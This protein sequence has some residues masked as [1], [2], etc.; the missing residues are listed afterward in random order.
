MTAEKRKTDRD[1]LRDCWGR[2]TTILAQFAQNRPARRRLDPRAYAALR[3]EL[4]A[5]CRS[6]AE[7]AGPER[8]FYVGLEET[9]K[10]WLNLRVFERTDREILGKLLLHCREV[11]CKLTGGRSSRTWPVHWKPAMAIVAIGAMVGGLV[12]LLPTQGLSALNTLRDAADTTWLTIK[13]AD[14]LQKTAGVAVIIVAASIYI[15]S[16]GT[17]A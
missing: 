2:W 9:V 17:R 15:A 3:H 10:P 7:A 1:V 16:R 8:L 11:E 4:I 13:Y 5:A 12:W 6:L 14:N